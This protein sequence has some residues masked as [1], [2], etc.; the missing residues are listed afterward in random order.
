M[1]TMNL[2]DKFIGD[3]IGSEQNA[4]VITFTEEEREKGMQDSVWKVLYYAFIDIPEIME[5]L[6]K[7]PTCGKK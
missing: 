7:C 5:K 4:I 3:A 6:G 1:K 2:F